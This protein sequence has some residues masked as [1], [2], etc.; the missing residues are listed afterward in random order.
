MALGIRTELAFPGTQLLEPDVYN[1]AFTM[2]A[3]VMIFF[4]VMPILAG[5]A[6]YVVPLQVEAAD[7]AFPRINALSFWII[8]FS[9]ILL[10]SSFVLGGAANAGWTSYVPLSDATYP[11]TTGQDKSGVP[12]ENSEDHSLVLSRGCLRE[13]I[14]RCA[15]SH[16][17][18]VAAMRSRG[19]SIDAPYLSKLLSGDKPIAQKHIDALPDD[20]EATYY[21]LQAERFGFIVVAPVDE[22]T[23]RRHLVSGLLG[24]LAPRPAFR[25]A[26]ATLPPNK[27]ARTA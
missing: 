21:G 1:Q 11:T 5:F 18:I 25:M 27:R 15:W 24:V 23:A 6:N 12:S 19:V 17:A 7:M 3:T 14:A 10:L 13:A 8:P 4:F 9:G 22:A 16:E 26:R 2:H 20:I